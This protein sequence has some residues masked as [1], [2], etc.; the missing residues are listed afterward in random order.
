M[1]FTDS[2]F[3]VVNHP[4]EGRDADPHALDVLR[5]KVEAVTAPQRAQLIA[6]A[7]EADA[8][9]CS[10]RPSQRGSLRRFELTR[11]AWRTVTAP[12]LLAVTIDGVHRIAAD[13]LSKAPDLM[14]RDALARTL[15]DDQVQPA[16][17]TGALLGS[18]NADEAQHLA[19]LLDQWAFPSTDTTDTGDTA[20]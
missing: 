7:K 9:M 16:W 14:M 4:D 1:R 18:C 6:W 11:A 17:P 8:A 13:M 15:G 3:R 5:G 12:T 20:A 19:H 2:P 10:F